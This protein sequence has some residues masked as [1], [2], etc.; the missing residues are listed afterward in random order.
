MCWPS[1]LERYYQLIKEFYLWQK[2]KVILGFSLSLNLLHNHPTYE[3]NL[4]R[5][6]VLKE[7]QNVTWR[8]TVFILGATS[9][10]I[11][12]IVIIIN[13]LLYFDLEM[14]TIM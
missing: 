3:K 13:N 14:T 8:Y 2:E 5:I 7:N 11:I 12:T 6:Q 9:I 1:V 10:I 4:E